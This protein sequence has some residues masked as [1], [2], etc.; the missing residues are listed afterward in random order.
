MQGYVQSMECNL[1]LT[2]RCEGRDHCLPAAADCSAT[3]DDDTR[4]GSDENIKTICQPLSVRMQQGT[5]CQWRPEELHTR[6]RL[7]GSALPGPAACPLPDLS[8]K[9]QKQARSPSAKVAE[10]G[11]PCVTCLYFH[12]YIG[13]V[14][15]QQLYGWE[16]A[17]PDSTV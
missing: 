17:G 6:R 12:V 4:A 15:Q 8:S 10:R 2:K 9:K 16:V 14:L 13:P 11:M 3:K 7:P 1:W 5:C